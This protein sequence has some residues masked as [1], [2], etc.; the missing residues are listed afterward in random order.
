MLFGID[1]SGIIHLAADS[2]RHHR[3]ERQDRVAR[4]DLEFIDSA[5]G[6][7]RFRDYEA[8]D[9]RVRAALAVVASG[10]FL[11]CIFASSTHIPPF[12][13]SYIGLFITARA[14]SRYWRLIVYCIVLFPIGLVAYLS[15]ITYHSGSGKR[16]FIDGWFVDS[17]F[18]NI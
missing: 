14:C 13:S 12:A 4:Y 10:L 11:S 1:I 6:G 2:C 16:V 17:G 15:D 18:A 9:V 8:K 3:R 7:A 5:P